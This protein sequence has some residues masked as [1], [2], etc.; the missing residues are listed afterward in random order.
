MPFLTVKCHFLQA[1]EALHWDMRVRYLVG[2]GRHRVPHPIP[3]SSYLT[4]C[5]HA[6]QIPFRLREMKVIVV[7]TV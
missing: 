6:Q 1:I 5:L 3:F 4:L 2:P 7:Q